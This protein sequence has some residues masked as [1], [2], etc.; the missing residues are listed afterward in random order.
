MSEQR[1]IQEGAR[2]IAQLLDNRK[3]QEVEDRLLSDMLNMKPADFKKLIETVNQQDT[4]N[5]GADLEL[6]FFEKQMRVCVA[7]IKAGKSENLADGFS[8]GTG[9]WR[10]NKGQVYDRVFGQGV[11]NDLTAAIE[12]NPQNIAQYLTRQGIREAFSKLT[13]EQLMTPEGKKTIQ[14]AARAAMLNAYGSGINITNVEVEVKAK[15]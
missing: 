13:H 2:E 10:F 3:T 12:Q 8:G 5:V 1:H 15:K 7:D 11:E 14:E 6:T 4:K 9:Q